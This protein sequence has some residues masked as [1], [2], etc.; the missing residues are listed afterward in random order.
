MSPTQRGRL[1][2]REEL[3]H[4][5]FVINLEIF[6]ECWKI[7]KC[8]FQTAVFTVTQMRGDSSGVSYKKETADNILIRLA[9]PM[10]SQAQ[11]ILGAFLLIDSLISGVSV[12]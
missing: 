3:H 5:A 11:C 10:F 1:G 6:F 9:D 7:F 4:G 12:R 8:S 2:S